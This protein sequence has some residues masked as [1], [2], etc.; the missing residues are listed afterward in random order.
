MTNDRFN[1]LVNLMLQHRRHFKSI[2]QEYSTKKKENGFIIAEV[3]D[4]SSTEIETLLKEGFGCNIFAADTRGYLELWIY[5]N[6]Y[7][8]YEQTNQ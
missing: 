1:Q 3:F 6:E 7:R 5:V 4:T 2:Y 8:S